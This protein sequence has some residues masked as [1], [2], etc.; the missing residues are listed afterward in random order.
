[1]RWKLTLL[2][3]S[4]DA[5]AAGETNEAALLLCICV[6]ILRKQSSLHFRIGWN[7]LQQQKRTWTEERGKESAGERKGLTA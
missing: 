1:M 4:A 3:Y 5:W 2:L 6:C 7:L